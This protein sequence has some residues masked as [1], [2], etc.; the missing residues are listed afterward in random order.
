MKAMKKFV[1]VLCAAAVV[2]S[3]LAGCGSASDTKETT[4]KET[5][6][7][8]EEAKETAANT[9]ASETEATV[10]EPKQELP[11]STDG[12]TLT[13]AIP[14]NSR[15]EDINTNQLTL[16]I[17]E[18]TGI[19][20]EFIELSTEDTA[21][22]VNTIMNGGDLPD[23][24]IGYNFPYDTLCSYADA[25]LLQPLDDYIDTWGYNLKNTIMEDPDLGE[26]VLGHATYDG[27]VWAMPSGG[28]LV[29]NVYK[30]Y[31]P[32][33]Q[34]ALLDELGMETP[35]T[36]EE[37]RTF[38]EAVKEKYPD[39]TPMT[40]FAD[41]NWIFANISQAYQF[42]DI[43]TYLKLN[44]GQVEFI[45][46]ND[47]FKEAIEYVK[48][49]V[50]DGLV[51]PASYT[52]DSSVLATQFAKEGIDAAVLACGY[53]ITT[54][55]DSSGEEYSTMRLTGYLEGP[56]GYVSPQVDRVS[57]RRSLVITS[58]CEYPEEAFR[59]FDFFLSDDF[60]IAARVGFEGEQ[61][62]AA[63]E[64]V[65]GRDG[66]QAWFSLLTDQEWVQTSTN[67]IWRTENLIHSNIMNHCAAGSSNLKY[68][69]EKFATQRLKDLRTDELLPLLVMS[70]EDT[71]EYNELKELIVDSVNSNIAL[72]ILGTRDMSEWDDFCKEL[73]AM[74]VDRYVEMAQTAYNTMTQ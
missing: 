33:I 13:V 37:L 74:G 10:S 43:D 8:S 64:G 4:T 30:K 72:F 57:V 61:W 62:E 31:Q 14:V 28:G 71:A 2:S 9:A 19:N 3:T 34:G 58:A 50:E 56:Y 7:A 26:N 63:A 65:L 60:A 24:F 44:D 1:C 22:Q 16:Y 17:E 66:E 55:M 70:A 45:A 27:Q 12:I 73:T 69:D 54:V 15:V 42:T 51:D 40:S 25:G 29:T 52:Q 47:L 49:L 46:N 21:T 35:D 38:L 48:E 36:L 23:I 39:I 41:Y 59:L 11:I 68:E 32:Y 18:Q 20:L 6:K 5:T 67:V 53:N